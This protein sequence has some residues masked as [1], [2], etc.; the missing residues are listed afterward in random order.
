MKHALTGAV[1]A[2]LTLLS[3]FQFP[4]HTY[5]QS[6]SQIYAAILEHLQ[7]PSTLRQDMLVHRPHV[8][9]TI[10]DEVALSLRSI[11]GL[12]FQHVLGLQ[13]VVLRGLGI[14]GVYLMATA[15]GLAQWPALLVAAILSLGGMVL[16][17]VVM[18][19]E[20]EPIPRGFAVPLLLLAIGL[21]A[22][23]YDFWA[24]TAASLA[25]L[26]HP[27]RSGRSGGF[28]LSWRW[29]RTSR[30]SCSRDSGHLCLCLQQ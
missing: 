23:Q 13:Q 18:I 8:S 5:L 19:W 3:F 29:C 12:D 22:H 27:P 21:V 1:L 11:T 24:G 28:T 7:D 17:P 14:W 6:D 20:Y 30:K 15:I 26:L 4:G 9:F 10:Y 25:F 16:G 2:V